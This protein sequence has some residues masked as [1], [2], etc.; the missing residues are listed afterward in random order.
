MVI[1]HY[2]TKFEQISSIGCGNM[3]VLLW[4][5]APIFFRR[6]RTYALVL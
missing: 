3:A 5:V 6:A 1:D 4:W 2:H